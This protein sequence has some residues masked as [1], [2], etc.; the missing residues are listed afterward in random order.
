MMSGERVL[1]VDGLSGLATH[2]DGDGS[3]QLSPTTKLHKG[4]V[5]I[6]AV[7]LHIGLK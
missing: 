1:Q 2:A 7:S 6:W 4:L 3:G 5:S